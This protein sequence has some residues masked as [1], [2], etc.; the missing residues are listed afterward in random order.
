[1]LRLGWS[2]DRTLDNLFIHL[3]YLLIFF[4]DDPPMI[5]NLHTIS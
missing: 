3:Y 2:G 5:F 4:N 1:M